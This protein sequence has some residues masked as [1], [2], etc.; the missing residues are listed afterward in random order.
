M[1]L[2]YVMRLVV[3]TKYTQGDIL[4]ILSVKQTFP[5]VHILYLCVILTIPPCGNSCK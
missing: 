3:Y 5:Q 2:A 1:Y 4:C